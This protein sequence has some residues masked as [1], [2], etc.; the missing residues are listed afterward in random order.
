M[1]TIH[2]LRPLNSTPLCRHEEV[3]DS[4]TVMAGATRAVL[5]PLTL[6]PS[7]APRMCPGCVV[8]QV[9]DAWMTESARAQLL[10]NL[11]EEVGGATAGTPQGV[12]TTS[13][14]ARAALECMAKRVPTPGAL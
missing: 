13:L 1:A 5:G 10:L 4:V 6:T 14:Y 11:V 7:G 8:A 2:I 12:E 3:K 9:T